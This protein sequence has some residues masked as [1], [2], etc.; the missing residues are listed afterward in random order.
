VPYPAAVAGISA[1][2]SNPAAR[3]LRDG[4]EKILS[5]ALAVLSPQENR[6]LSEVDIP[7]LDQQQGTD[8]FGRLEGGPDKRCVED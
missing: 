6:L 4:A 8:A 3:F 1:E 2:R 5:R 7:P